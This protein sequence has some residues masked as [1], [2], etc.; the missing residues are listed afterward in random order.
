MSSFVPVF[1]HEAA[2]NVLSDHCKKVLDCEICSQFVFI[3][4]LIILFRSGP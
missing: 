3:D 4:A 1:I 2:L